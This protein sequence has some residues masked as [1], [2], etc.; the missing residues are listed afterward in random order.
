M[1]RPAGPLSVTVHD[2][3]GEPGAPSQVAREVADL[4]ARAERALLGHT[5]FH[6]RA[7]TLAAYARDE[8]EP[9][10]IILLRDAGEAVGFLHVFLP[11]HA[12]I[13]HVEAT[14]DPGRDAQPLLDTLWPT[15]EDL[16]RREERTSLTWWESS[17]Q[18]HPTLPAATG[19]GAVES[20]AVTEWLRERGFVLDQVEVCSTLHLPVGVGEVDVDKHYEVVTWEGAMPERLLDGMARLRA[21]MSRDAPKGSREGEERWDAA[22]IRRDEDMARRARRSQLWAVAL[23]E[24]GEPV[25]YTMIECPEGVP[26]IAYQMDT[27]V[28]PEDR[29]HGLGRALKQT[30]LARLQALRPGVRRVHTWNA[31]E[32]RWMLAINRGMGFVPS[33]AV[34]AWQRT[35]RAADLPR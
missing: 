17:R 20:S 30:N 6:Y 31:G 35:D 7:D 29:G 1:D 18:D 11:R 26:E 21:R 16:C 34:G 23:A 9:Q 19:V 33:S 22:R 25:G 10:L 8:D 24:S 27:L 13:V 4:A 28:Q 14:L 12:H 2:D 5:D 32:N 15:F 3:L